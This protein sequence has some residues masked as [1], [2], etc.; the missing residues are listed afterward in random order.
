MMVDRF[1]EMGFPAEK[2]HKALE[3][4][5]GRQ[6]KEAVLEWLVAHQEV[7]CSVLLISTNEVV[8]AGF[9]FFHVCSWL[10]SSAD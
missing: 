9:A 5:G 2:V 3:H 1:I 7:I 8:A 6:D 10:L 4:A